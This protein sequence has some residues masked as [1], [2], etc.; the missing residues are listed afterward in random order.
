ME[1]QIYNYYVKMRGIESFSKIK[2][3]ILANIL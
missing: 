1:S 3:K 2:C